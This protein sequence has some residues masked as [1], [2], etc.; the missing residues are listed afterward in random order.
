MNVEKIKR[1]LKS[2]LPWRVRYF[3]KLQEAEGKIH[4]SEKIKQYR[5]IEEYNQQLYQTLDELK[6]ESFEDKVVCELGPGQ[7]LSHAFLEYQMGAKKEWLLEIADFAHV[8]ETA[9]VE[10]LHLDN[11]LKKINQLPAI[12]QNES[13]LSYLAK[14]NATYITTGING[15]KNIPDGSVDYCFSYAVLEHIRRN[16]VEQT[17]EEMYRFTRNG[18]GWLSYS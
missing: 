2:C 14:V 10:D 1:A 8:N 6:I 12:E 17:I 15:Y 16:I 13:W 7:H 18:G 9:K 4:L 11:N 5:G 3:I